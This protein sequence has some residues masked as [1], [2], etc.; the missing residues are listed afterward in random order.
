MSNT[1]R[2]MLIAWAPSGRRS[3]SLARELG[4]ELYFIHYLKFRNPLYAPVKYILQAIRTFQVLLVKH[5]EVIFVQNPPFVCGLVVYLYCR[6]TGAS[7][8]LDCHSDAFGRAWDWALPIQKFLAR[9]AITNIVTNQHWAE[10]IHSWTAD[11]FILLDPLPKLPE[12]L[13]FAVDPGFNVVFVNTFA[14]DEPL[15]LVLEAAHQLQNVH[16]YI[17]GNTQRKPDSFFVNVPPNV[18]FTGFLPDTQY[19]G[20]LRAAQAVMA[21]TTRDHTLQGSGFEAVSLGKPLI[22]S[23]WPYLQELFPK[24]TVYVS[25]S[26]QGIRDGILAMQKMHTTLE[27]QMLAFRQESKRAWDKQFAQ[28]KETIAN[29]SQARKI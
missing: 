9:R 23:D 12:G 7:F 20:L 1:Q 17:T 13:D 6:M 27:K 21:L 28:L 11:A 14:P 19:A 10:I 29:H 25:N 4:A 8:V 15:D 24:G 5:P 2:W 18:T 22:T 3:E 16:F 26:S